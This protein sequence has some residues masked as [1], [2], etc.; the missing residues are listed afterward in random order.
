MLRIATTVL[1]GMKP[2][3][4]R[5]TWP[6]APY[7]LGFKTTTRSGRAGIASLPVRRTAMAPSRRHSSP[8]RESRVRPDLEQA[9]ARAA[10]DLPVND[11]TGT[12][13]GR[14]G[15]PLPALASVTGRKQRGLPWRALWSVAALFLHQREAHLG[16]NE[17][18]GAEISVSTLERALRRSYPR[19]TA[20]RRLEQS[21]AK[22][23]RVPQDKPAV[24]GVEEEQIV[25]IALNL[26]GKRSPAPGSASIG[27]AQEARDLPAALRGRAAQP[28]ER[29]IQEREDVRVGKLRPFQHPR[30][31]AISGR[32]EESA[33]SG[34]QSRA[35]EPPVEE[36]EVNPRAFEIAREL[37]P[38]APSV[39]SADEMLLRVPGGGPGDPASSRVEE[40]EGWL[41]VD[42]VGLDV[43]ET[44]PG[45][46]AV[47]SVENRTGLRDVPA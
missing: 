18:H 34:R 3:R 44:L 29:R 37:L 31:A 46:P 41:D 15:E 21:A 7:L 27:R 19:P 12:R 38:P 33:L 45:A 8:I 1:L 6:S 47:R 24:Q 26:V 4:K 28:S 9:H 22:V 20:V 13:G 32:C 16:G 40:P 30:G 43:L 39:E 10:P 2:R 11:L 42:T 36:A 5:S 25:R 17:S 14:Q 35:A 23:V